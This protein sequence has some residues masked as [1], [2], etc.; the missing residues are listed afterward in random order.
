[1]SRPASGELFRALLRRA[2]GGRGAGAWLLL[3]AG[4]GAAAGWLAARLLAAGLGDR[5][6]AGI[7]A[8]LLVHFPYTALYGLGL[9]GAIQLLVCYGDDARSGWTAQFLAAGATRDRYLLAL[10]F[11]GA[12]ATA[13]LY[14]VSVSSWLVVATA[15][16][17][18]VPLLLPDTALLLVALLWLAT[19][20]AFAAAAVAIT[21]RPGGAVALMLAV[22]VVPWILLATLGGPPDARLAR[23]LM[24]ATAAAPPYPIAPGVLAPFTITAYAGLG[25][26]FAWVFAPRRLLRL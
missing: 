20:S 26:A 11:A 2:L 7:I 12:C 23:W 9:L 13:L 21:G 22:V 15:F 24:W 6:S 14:L 1:M 5:P 16:G 18:P 4:V 3:A 25:L 8:W 17:R 19:P 10:A